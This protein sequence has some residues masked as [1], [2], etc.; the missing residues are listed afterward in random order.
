MRKPFQM[1]RHW[2]TTT[3]LLTTRREATD[4]QLPLVLLGRWDHDRRTSIHDVPRST[5]PFTL[6]L[7]GRTL[8]RIG[9]VVV[10]VLMVEGIRPVTL[11]D[12]KTCG[13]HSVGYWTCTVYFCFDSSIPWE[14]FCGPLGN[15]FDNRK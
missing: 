5:I 7:R 11:R 12:R 13:Y 4:E 6:T 8:L 3:I 10:S 9:I 14:Y 2:G 15:I 1:A